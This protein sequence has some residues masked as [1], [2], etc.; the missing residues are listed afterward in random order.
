[1]KKFYLFTIVAMLSA[2]AMAQDVVFMST[3]GNDENDGLTAETSVRNMTR[4][5]T[6]LNSRENPEEGT[7]VICGNYLQESDF[8]SSSPEHKHN[9]PITITQVYDGVDYRQEANGYWELTK[10]HIYHLGGPT[11]FK[12]LT[13]HQTAS[14]SPYFLLIANSYPVTID[15]GCVMEGSFGWSSFGDSFALIG[16]CRYVSSTKNDDLRNPDSYGSEITINDGTLYVAAY[17][18]GSIPQ[19]IKDL[20]LPSTPQSQVTVNGGTIYDLCCGST[21]KELLSGNVELVI[22]GGEFASHIYVGT[23][24]SYWTNGNVNVKITGGNFSGWGTFNASDKNEES[25]ITLDIRNAG[26]NQLP[27]LSHNP[28]NIFNSIS[29]DYKVPFFDFTETR[30]FT[31]PDNSTLPYRLAG[32]S[33]DANLPVLLFLDKAP[34]SDLILSDEGTAPLYSLFNS[35]PLQ[36]VAP[37][38]IIETEETASIKSEGRST[39]DSDIGSL[40]D[41]VIANSQSDTDRVYLLASASAVQEGWEILNNYTDKFAAAIICGEGSAPSSTSAL[42]VFSGNEHQSANLEAASDPDLTSWLFDQKLTKSTIVSLI[43]NDNTKAEISA[44]ANSLFIKIN[45]PDM[46]SVYR[47]DGTVIQT[48]VL[49]DTITL[50]NISAGFYIIK[51]GNCST[52]ILVGNGR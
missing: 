47:I 26:K 43:N 5:F 9:Y 23:H 22:N 51:I 2:S 38:L 14:K 4:A 15:Q 52:R 30:D 24:G 21:S 1:M 48:P 35:N 37:S 7:I 45:T 32:S 11:I 18:R 49:S 28:V 39:A 50:N 10:G 20:E 17:N 34:S 29:T 42:K 40:L 41:Q 25:V 27:I 19:F 46:I 8:T 3:S 6:I 13:F 36:I 31:S 44:D 33:V 16:G 12:D